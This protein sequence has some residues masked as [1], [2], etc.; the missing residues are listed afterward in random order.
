MGKLYPEDAL[1]PAF[2]VIHA[3]VINNDGVVTVYDRTGKKMTNYEGA[4]SDKSTSILGDADSY[5]T[6]T[7]QD[8][9][10]GETTPLT[11]QEAS[12]LF[13]EG[14]GGGGGGLFGG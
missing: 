6:F 5:V 4:W 10:T 7:Y 3:V 14:S 11:S 1:V 12:A 9:L 2:G 13:T 8:I